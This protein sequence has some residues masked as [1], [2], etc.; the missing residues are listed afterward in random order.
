MKKVENV[1]N[2]SINISNSTLS[3]T[4]HSGSITKPHV[5]LLIETPFNAAFGHWVFESALHLRCLSD[6]AEQYPNIKL[7]L[8]KKPH[9]TYKTLFTKAFMI[10]SNKIIWIDNI[11]TNNHSCCYENLPE[12]NI[13]ILPDICCLNHKILPCKTTFHNNIL[14]LNQGLTNKY[15]LDYTKTVD[16]LFFPRNK[17]QNFAVNDRVIQ[18]DNVYRFLKGKQYIEYN[19]LD[20]DDLKTQLQLLASAKNIFLDYGSSYYVNGIFC[21]NSNIYISGFM[22]QFAYEGNQTIHNFI[23][24]NN[25]ITILS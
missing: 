1:K 11:E 15:N 4:Y 24:T 17:S 12:N 7:V 23:K 19:T 8:N 9:R 13:C 20:T 5:F 18:Y 21:K 25:N 22:D 10:P 3:F 16:N 2:V 6:L 14:L